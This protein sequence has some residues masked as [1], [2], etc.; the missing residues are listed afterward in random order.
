[1]RNEAMMNEPRC[2]RCGAVVAADAPEG[3]GALCLLRMRLDSAYPRAHKSDE[4]V[5]CVFLALSGLAVLF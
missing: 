3:K 5:F 2:Q 4:P 1:M